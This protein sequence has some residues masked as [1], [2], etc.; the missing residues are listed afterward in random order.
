MQAVIT[1]GRAGSKCANIWTRTRAGQRFRMSL[2]TWQIKEYRPHMNQKGEI[3]WILHARHGSS[4]ASW[5]PSQRIINE[6]KELAAHMKVAYKDY[7][8]QYQKVVCL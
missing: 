5:A 4:V 6:A 1:V 2:P 3:I 8:A 7:V